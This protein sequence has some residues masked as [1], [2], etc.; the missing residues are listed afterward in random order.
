MS[1]IKNYDRALYKSDFDAVAHFIREGH[2]SEYDF[3]VCSAEGFNNALEYLCVNNIPH[4]YQSYDAI[5][6]LTLISII[7]GDNVQYSYCFWCKL[8]GEGNG[9]Y[10]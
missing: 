3:G 7:F 4:T 1:K 5:D 9:Y 8:K 2:L 6:G 10:M